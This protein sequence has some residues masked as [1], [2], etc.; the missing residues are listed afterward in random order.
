[1]NKRSLNSIRIVQLLGLMLLFITSLASAQQRPVR[2]QGARVNDKE[3]TVLQSKLREQK[4]VAQGRMKKFANKKIKTEGNKTIKLGTLTRVAFVEQDKFATEVGKGSSV[5]KAI[6]SKPTVNDSVQE[7]PDSYIITKS[8]TIVVIDPG[9]LAQSSPIYKKFL[10]QRKPQKIKLN[11]LS[12]EEKKGLKEFMKKASSLSAGDP[13]RQAAEQ[14]EQKVLDAIAAGKGE[15]TVEDTLIIPKDFTPPKDGTVMYP[16]FKNGLI[17]YSTLKKAA[18]PALKSMALLSTGPKKDLAAAVRPE[19]V[20]VSKTSPPTGGAQTTEKTGKHTFQE[21]FLAGF[22]IG[23]AWQWERRWNYHSGFFRITIGG[24]FGFGLRI[25]VRVNGEVEPTK[26]LVYRKTDRKVT[27]T[28]QLR[29]ETLDANKQYYKNVGIAPSQVFEG[30]EVVLEYMFGYGYKFRALWTDVAQKSFSKTGFNYSQN[31]KPPLGGNCSSCGF[32]IP[33]PPEITR[34]K[35]KIADALDG[36]VQIGL[37]V[38]GN[39][40]VGF[41]YNDIVGREPGTTKRNLMFNSTSPQNITIS[42]PKLTLGKDQTEASQSYGFEIDH[43]KYI[44]GVS[45]TPEV[46]VGI[47]VGYKSFS[48]TFTTDWIELNMFTRRI[49]TVTLYRHKGTTTNY[50]YTNGKK[51]FLKYQPTASVTRTDRHKAV[52]AKTSNS[53]GAK[54]RPMSKGKAAKATKKKKLN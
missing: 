22:T 38:N 36:F 19:K 20:T 5:G 14:G 45:V 2:A 31:T 51:T 46:R 11:K 18:M 33:I 8:T 6:L 42:V 40:R 9:K 44:L 3:I 48:R 1:M 37:H 4:A 41:E 10:N 29:V 47:K 7:F 21:D 15:L 32:H 16:V 23:N 26:I 28:G 49:G 39:G 53:G 25:P 13:L 43:F 35:F 12:K 50:K 34:T 30:K 17:N 24:G 52:P 54:T 27:A